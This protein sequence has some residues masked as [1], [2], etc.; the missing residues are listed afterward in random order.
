[1]SNLPAGT[2]TFLFT[3]IEG[4]TRLWQ[5]DADAMQ[6]AL[7]RH[8]EILTVAVSAHGGHVFKHTGDGMCAAFAS[9]S[10]ALAAAV[11]GQ[12]ALRR[13]DW[14]GRPALRARMGVHTG[15]AEPAG[16]DYFGT[17]LNRC[18][19][20]M[21]AAHGGQIV[22]TSAAE[23]TARGQLD[24]VAL[25]DLG[26]HRLRDLIEP[27]HLYQLEHADLDGDFP[28]LRS[29]DAHRH[30]LPVPRT[31][32]IG[33]ERE[34]EALVDAL[35]SDRLV[36]VTGVG[37][38]GK[39]RLALQAAADLVDGYADGV[40]LVELAAV[41]EPSA[42]VGQIADAM[43][44]RG[45]AAPHDEQAVQRYLH[46][47]TMLIV[48]DNCEHVLDGC[49]SVCDNL[50][51]STRAVTVLCT[52]REPLALAGEH[53]VRI[54]SLGVTDTDDAGLAAVAA[55]EAGQLFA[56]RAASVQPG[57]AILP[58]HATAV[59]QICRR[60]DGI[61]LAIELAAARVRHLSVQQIADRLD[62]R[63]RLLTGGGRS[64]L[65]RHQTLRATLDWSHDLLSDEEQVLLR[66]LSVFVGWFTLEAAE[67]LCAGDTVEELVVFDLLGRLVDRSLVAVEEDL[68]ETRYR[69][70]ETV[71]HYAQEHLV[72]AD[73]A[74]P[75]RDRHRD[76]FADFAA[77]APRATRLVRDPRVLREY[78]NFRAA[79]DWAIVTEAGPS[80]LCLL[81]GLGHSWIVRG[82]HEEAERLAA[83]V[84]ES[85]WALA[86]TPDF[87]ATILLRAGFQAMVGNFARSLE[88]SAEAGVL[89]D[90][91]GFDDLRPEL[92]FGMAIATSVVGTV[93]EGEAL[94]V[95]A[96]ECALTTGQPRMAADALTELAGFRL[97][98]DPAQAIADLERAVDLYGSADV[99]SRGALATLAL[100]RVLGGDVDG[101]YPVALEAASIS[102]ATFG[103]PSFEAEVEVP[104]G[105]SLAAAGRHEDGKRL[106]DQTLAAFRK[107]GLPLGETACLVGYGAL[108][109]Y[110]G[111]P[112]LG[113]RLLAAARRSFGSEGGWRAP[114][115]G[116]TYVRSVARGRELVG[117]DDARKA[118]DEGMAMSREEAFALVEA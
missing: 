74:A 10:A 61:P 80:A 33:R 115:V 99:H 45:G 111:D 43:G 64:S 9:P 55:S 89:I 105:I 40:F 93:A 49:A 24:E 1:M 66:R 68:G 38:S 84:S 76:W 106:I 29:L 82:L 58:S 109:V 69:L 11:Q 46:S 87:V 98:H 100:S 42:I 73:E 30:N 51:S 79:L 94:L 37:G 108:E 28:P 86:S 113:L 15:P 92:L 70:L 50:L 104:I 96:I 39:T 114:I 91:Y 101:A 13:E 14:G 5:E 118:R 48:L 117:P 19:R 35:A 97:G 4:S 22:C 116:A 8:D 81:G 32:F 25:R 44:L 78:D 63:F 16:D 112:H 36:T 59:A 103:D 110:G 54:P 77:R 65:P 31:S 7:G 62:D 3:D 90:R 26:E 27:E 17:T 72:D 2:V 21:A 75:L 52:S 67:G 6:R 23:S 47:R 12:R 102:G 18:A 56:D 95:Q 71:R 57:Y 88:H 107:I 20:V 83:V 34:L 85:S 60:L 41:I 53:I